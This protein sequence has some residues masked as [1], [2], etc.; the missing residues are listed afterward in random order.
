[1]RR[2]L[3]AIEAEMAKEPTDIRPPMPEVEEEQSV[4]VSEQKPPLPRGGG[5]KLKLSWR[6]C[7]K[8]LTTLS[9]KDCTSTCCNQIVYINH[10]TC[11]DKRVCGYDSKEDKW[12]FLP[13]TP[14][15]GSTLTAIKDKLTA[16]GGTVKQYIHSET[17]TNTLFSLNGKG[18][19]AK[20]SESFQPMPTKRCYTTVVC[21]LQFLVVMGGRVAARVRGEHTTEHT[22][23]IEVMDCDTQQW[24]T[25]SSL[26]HPFY[27]DRGVAAICRNRLYL[28][29]IGRQALWVCSVRDLLKSP[30][31]AMEWHEIN[32]HATNATL[33]NF[34]EQLLVVGG[35]EADEKDTN[36]IH[37]FD[38]ETGI[39][40]EISKMPTA[41]S[42]SLAIALSGDRLMV[43]GGE[44]HYEEYVEY[45]FDKVRTEVSTRQLCRADIATIVQ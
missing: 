21:S 10:S 39:W 7:K 35:S 11:S 23:V 20:W 40:E 45:D 41:R 32:L 5:L 38:P 19:S 14:C 29:E 9:L 25:A 37:V 3:E 6:T 31:V 42:N 15:Y 8:A 33:V 44:E 28:M 22:T 1:M 27:I 17:V 30:K 18:I 26:R 13:D 2:K 43:V 24:S 36:G 34:C 16:V 4:T 12:F